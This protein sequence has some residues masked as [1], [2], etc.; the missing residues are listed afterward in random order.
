M[1]REQLVKVMLIFRTMDCVRIANDDDDDDDDKALLAA[2]LLI[3][4]VHLH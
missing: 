1:T 3:V 2:N 4:V